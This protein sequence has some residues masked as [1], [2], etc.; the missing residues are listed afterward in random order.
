MIKT[1][2][3]NNTHMCYL[4]DENENKIYS[5][6]PKFA[7][8]KELYAAE[9]EYQKLTNQFSSIEKSDTE[10]VLFDHFIYEHNAQVA[11]VDIESMTSRNVN[12]IPPSKR[13]KNGYFR[14]KLKY[15][16][17]GECFGVTV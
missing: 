10:V 7:T 2:S 8:Q 12:Y 15:R 3:K 1:D 6:D 13:K 5:F 14:S 4:V 9:L 17:I 16:E 11:L